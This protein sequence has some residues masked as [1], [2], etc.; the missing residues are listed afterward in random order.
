[1]LKITK[2]PNKGCQDAPR[3][4]SERERYYLLVNL[5]LLLPVFFFFFFS[6]LLVSPIVSSSLWKRSEMEGKV[7]AGSQRKAGLWGLPYPAGS[8]RGI[9]PGQN[10][11]GSHSPAPVILTGPLGQS[12]LWQFLAVPNMVLD[13]CPGA[14]WKSRLQVKKSRINWPAAKMIFSFPSENAA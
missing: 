2:P 8:V 6:L 7:V 13:Q 10:P 14:C 11:A 1:M 12:L 3:L 4:H 5:C 9:W